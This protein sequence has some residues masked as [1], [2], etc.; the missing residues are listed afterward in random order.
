MKSILYHRLKGFGLGAV[1]LL[2]GVVCGLNQASAQTSAS[3]PA[4][5]GSAVDK[6]LLE[7]IRKVA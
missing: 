6:R 4:A 1:V 7:A 3:A 2:A 5:P